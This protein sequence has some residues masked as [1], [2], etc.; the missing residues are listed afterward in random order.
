ML[1]Q[2]SA[3][4]VGAKQAGLSQRHYSLNKVVSSNPTENA[5]AAS[6]HNIQDRPYS[7]AQTTYHGSKDISHISLIPNLAQT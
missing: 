2:Q 3:S 7:T 6:H 5:V 1:I 4:N